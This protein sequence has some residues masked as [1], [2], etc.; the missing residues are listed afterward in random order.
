M[1]YVGRCYLEHL[2]P[3]DLRVLAGHGGGRGVDDLRADPSR[4]EEALASPAT[5]D[6]VFLPGGGDLLAEVSP[7]LAFALAVHRAAVTLRGTVAVDEWVGPRRR[8]PVLGGPQLAEFLSDPARRLFLAELLA[9][10]THVSS[11]AVWER[12]GRGWRRRRFSELDPVQLAGLVLTAPEPERPGVYRR[13]GDLAL[14]LTGIFPDASAARRFPALAAGQLLHSGGVAGAEPPEEIFGVGRVGLLEYLG[15][16]WYRLAFAT[17]PE[18]RSASLHVVA[19]VAARFG[20]A[21]RILN[22]LADRYLFP[23]REHWSAGPAG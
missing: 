1:S 6:A 3:T 21:R 23:W 22:L 5:F 9:S 16:R 20:D 15:Q 7:F 2:T 12:T 10:Y 4:L 11:G 14:F 18:P 8:V 17:A 13:L 19:D